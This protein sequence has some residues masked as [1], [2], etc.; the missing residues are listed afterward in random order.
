MSNYASQ[1]HLSHS[2]F[3]LGLVLTLSTTAVF[4][5]LK[6]GLNKA[7]IIT[8]VTYRMTSLTRFCSPRDGTRH[9][10]NGIIH[11]LRPLPTSVAQRDVNDLQDEV[12]RHYEDNPNWDSFKVAEYIAEYFNEDGTL[13]KAIKEKYDRE[14]KMNDVM[15]FVFQKAA[16]VL[17]ND[18]LKEYMLA[19]IGVLAINHVPS[20]R[21]AEEMKMPD[22]KIHIIPA[23]ENKK[24]TY[25]AEKLVRIFDLL[26]EREL[27]NMARPKK[28]KA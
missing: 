14:E 3:R 18:E 26:I 23:T 21:P 4:A 25:V 20:T 27:A 7:F 17:Q 10:I 15:Y 6:G 9:Q 24:K 12:C 13:N 5:S 1:T 2:F 19:S 11:H 28:G 8:G 22:G 16:G